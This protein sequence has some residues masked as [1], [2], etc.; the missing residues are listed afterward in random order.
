MTEAQKQGRLSNPPLTI[1]P[2]RSGES[3]IFEE[4]S[5]QTWDAMLLSSSFPSV[6]EWLS[7]WLLKETGRYCA[8]SSCASKAVEETP[9]KKKR[10]GFWPLGPVT[11]GLSFT[12]WQVQGG[13]FPPSLQCKRGLS[14]ECT[15]K[16][17]LSVKMF[18]PWEPSFRG[19]AVA[20]KQLAGHVLGRQMERV[21]EM[22]SWRRSVEREE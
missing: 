22:I 15:P 2:S 8:E 6:G 4:H 18:C 19:L 14:L 16:A 5:P 20:Q 3:F 13:H 10:A 7:S 1:C 17:S 21:M 9:E 12:V 11:L